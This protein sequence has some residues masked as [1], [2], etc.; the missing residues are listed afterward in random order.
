[1]TNVEKLNKIAEIAEHYSKIEERTHFKD[2]LEIYHDMENI[3]DLAREIIRSIEHVGD[4]KARHD[5]N[6]ELDDMLDDLFREE[7]IID[8]E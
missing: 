6:S 4:Y 7:D 8:D 1:M 2:V 5:F 3:I